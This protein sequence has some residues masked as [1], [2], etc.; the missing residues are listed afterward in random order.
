MDVFSE[1]RFFPSFSWLVVV[2]GLG[3]LRLVRLFAVGWV[4]VV[5]VLLLSFGLLSSF[6]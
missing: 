1:A 5:G 2:T 3:V 6:E 4:A